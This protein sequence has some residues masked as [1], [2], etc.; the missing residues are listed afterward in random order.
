MAVLLFLAVMAGG[1]LFGPSSHGASK[2][3]ADAWPALGRK[4]RIVQVSSH[5]DCG[6]AGVRARALRKQKY[7]AGVLASAAYAPLRPGYCVVYVGPF[8][9]STAGT[10]SAT[11]IS[12]RLPGSK[13]RDVSAR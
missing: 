7:A 2:P 3:V 11:K 6:S 5:T 1:A 10:R 8:P 13:V 9:R 4:A 12:D